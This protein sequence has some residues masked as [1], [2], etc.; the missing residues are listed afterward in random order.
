MIVRRVLVGVLAS[1]G[2]FVLSGCELISPTSTYRQKITVELET[3]D[4]PKTG[5]AI[6][7]VS[8]LEITSSNGGNGNALLGGEAVAIDV[9]PKKTLFALLGS[10]S[11]A[12]R[13]SYQAQLIGDALN[14]GARAEPP[15]NFPS[16]RYGYSV[17]DHKVIGDSR[18]Q[19]DLPREL[20]PMLVTFADDKDLTS[21]MLVEPSDLAARF[22]AGVKLKRIS[23]AVTDEPVTTGIEKRL[24]A[25]GFEKG[26]G[27]DRTGIVNANLTLAQRLSYNDFVKGQ[28]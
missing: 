10:A 9:A 19:L 25:M 7:E 21:V 13:S 17:A 18:V 16:G 27:L 8:Y 15:V 5:S 12:D 6:V 23:V 28:D 24:I 26:R 4:G 14:A 2:A 1:V 22:G 3:L 11:G 20:Y